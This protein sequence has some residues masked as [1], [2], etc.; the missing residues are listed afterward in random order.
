MHCLV[1]GDT[2]TENIKIGD[3]TLLEAAARR[4]RGGAS[5][6]EVQE[7]LAA[8]TPSGIGLKFLDPRAIGF[9]TEGA[10]TLDDP[11]YD[12]KPWHNSIGH[13]DEMHNEF[14]DLD[15][16]TTADGMPSISIH[17]LRDNPYRQ[18]YRVR[19]V[20]EQGLQVDRL[21]RSVL[22]TTLPGS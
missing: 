10:Q 3:I 1:I 17:F 9:R 7:A 19:D 16:S 13:Y 18:A 14:F 20:V 2:N 22:R 12:N 4:I 5:D 21:T 15:L 6:A 8:I 11:M